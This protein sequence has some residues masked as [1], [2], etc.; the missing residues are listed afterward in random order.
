MELCNDGDNKDNGEHYEE[1]NI[2]DSFFES[3]VQWHTP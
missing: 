2:K 1:E 3:W